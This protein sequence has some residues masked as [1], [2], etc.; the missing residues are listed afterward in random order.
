MFSLY[1]F[2][3]VLENLLWM[4]AKL[5]LFPC[6]RR[7][8]LCP[9]GAYFNCDQTN[10]FPTTSEKSRVS[11]L[12]LPTNKGCNIVPTLFDCIE[13]KV[14]INFLRGK[15]HEY[16]A[17]PSSRNNLYR[18]TLLPRTIR[19]INGII[20]EVPECDVFH[21]KEGRLSEIVSSYLSRLLYQDETD[22]NPQME[23]REDRIAPTNPHL[24]LRYSTLHPINMYICS[25]S[26]TA[27]L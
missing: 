14:P 24:S 6:C 23:Y 27:V 8:F 19:Y 12:H 11:A 20:V 9:F 26:A 13:L 25:I 18:T 15:H 16:L 5:A 17:V 4:C 22:E 10:L 2:Y 1:F 7:H 3:F 21:M